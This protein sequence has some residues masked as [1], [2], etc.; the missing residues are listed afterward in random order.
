VISL[1]IIY[2]SYDGMTDPLGQSQVLPYLIGLSKFNFEIH[3]IS[4]E[5]EDKFNLRKDFIVDLIKKANIIWHPLK[6]HQSPPVLSTLYDLWA[7]NKKTKEITNN[8]AIDL[9]HCRSYIS[10]LIGL[11][12]KRKNGIPF[13]F[14][15][16]GFWADERIDGK[17]WNLNNP[18]FKL[19]YRFFKNKEKQ[20]ICES[21]YIVSLTANA[22]NEIQGWNLDANIGSKI[23]VIPCCADL[24]HFSLER[25]NTDLI[26]QFESNLGISGHDFLISYIGSLGTW[27]MIEE[28]MALFKVAQQKIANCKFLIITADHPEI[29]YHAAK[30]LD[31]LES[32]IIVRKAERNEVPYLISLSKFSIFFIKPSYSKK[33]SSPTKLAEILGMGVPVICN[34]NVGDVE[35]IVEQ[36]KVGFVLKDFNGP[37]YEKAIEKMLAFLP[38]DTLSISNYAKKYASLKDGID[39]YHEIYKKI[40]KPT[41]DGKIRL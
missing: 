12:L 34:A 15:M 27:Y 39:K 13:L 38:A 10:S 40:I 22:K 36:G 41:N 6:Y 32:S 33:A 20:F 30:K 31:I 28:M 35:Q 16:R 37:A 23:K 5:K 9:V 11:K 25:L 29:A 4:F 8:H 26:K 3:L 1:K 17:I 18:I 7:L 24:E 21:D 2:I 19:I 14:D